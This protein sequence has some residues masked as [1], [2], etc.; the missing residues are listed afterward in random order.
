VGIALFK[1]ILKM[2][3]PHPMVDHTN[4]KQKNFPTIDYALNLKVIQMKKTN[5]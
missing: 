4:G 5:K 2:Q 1:T 3:Y